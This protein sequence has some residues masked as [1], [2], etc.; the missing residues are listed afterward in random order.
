MSNSLFILEK[1]TKNVEKKTAGD[2]QTKVLNI[3]LIL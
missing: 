1:K 2:V 3:P